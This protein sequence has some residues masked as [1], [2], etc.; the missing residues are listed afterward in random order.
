MIFKKLLASKTIQ[1]KFTDQKKKVYWQFYQN[2]LNLLTF[3]QW[4]KVSFEL[5]KKGLQIYFD[6]CDLKT[7]T[8]IC[9]HKSIKKSKLSS[10]VAG[11]AQWNGIYFS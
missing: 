8:I 6:Y 3:T 10:L 9:K 7:Y 4:A 1:N 2:P 5:E 11:V